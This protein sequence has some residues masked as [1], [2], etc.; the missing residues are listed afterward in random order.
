MNS[1]VDDGLKERI[2]RVRKRIAEAAVR[3]G[4]DPREIELIAVSKSV[5][6]YTINQA[7]ASGVEILGENRVQELAAK[8]PLV[9]KA[10]RWHFIGS[11]QRNKVRSLIG[12]VE[13][14]HSLDR[15]SLAREISARSKEKGVVTPVLV[16]VNLSGEES[17]QGIDRD[18]AIPFIEETASMEGIF[19]TGLMTIAPLVSP[20]ETREVFRGLKQLRDQVELKG[21]PGVRMNHLSM[22]MTNDFE[23]AVEEGATLVRV[24]TAI[25]GP[26]GILAKE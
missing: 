12:R 3:A 25:F 21:I 4:R 10:A 1:R 7:L 14:I 23:V 6:P 20:S 8:Q 13:M 19:I 22:G 18:E 24:G 17:K 2:G 11:L 5:D 9:E 16:Q 15:I 26:R